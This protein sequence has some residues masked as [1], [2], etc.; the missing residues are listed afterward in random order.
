[1]FKGVMDSRYVLYFIKHLLASSPSHKVISLFFSTEFTDTKE[2]LRIKQEL[3]LFS[4]LSL[5]AQVIW[6]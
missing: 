2:K 5:D 1:M 4:R 3:Q 6:R